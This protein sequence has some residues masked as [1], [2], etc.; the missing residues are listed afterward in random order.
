MKQEYVLYI[1][2]TVLFC[3]SYIVVYIT[4]AP[5]ANPPATH[6]KQPLCLL[7]HRGK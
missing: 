4:V 3:R 7:L 6:Y 2:T 5:A 1:Q